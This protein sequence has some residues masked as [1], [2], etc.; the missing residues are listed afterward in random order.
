[1][2]VNNPNVGNL[3]LGPRTARWDLPFAVRVQHSGLL[4]TCS[5]TWA[6]GRHLIPHSISH[7]RWH[8]AWHH[9]ASY[10]ACPLALLP[11]ILPGI[12]SRF[13]VRIPSASIPFAIILFRIFTGRP[14]SILC[15]AAAFYFGILCGILLGKYCENIYVI[16]YEQGKKMIKKNAL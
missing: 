12:L 1:M 10:V 6:M 15:H 14:P 8:G 16:R 4:T 9:L 2:H 13:F 7:S 3:I 11:S 5:K